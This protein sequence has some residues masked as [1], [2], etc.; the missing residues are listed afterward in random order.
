MDFSKQTMAWMGQMVSM[1]E[2]NFWMDFSAFYE[3]LASP[4]EAD[5]WLNEFTREILDVKHERVKRHSGTTKTL[6]RECVRCLRPHGSIGFPGSWRREESWSES[7][8]M[9]MFLELRARIKIVKIFG[10]PPKHHCLQQV[11]D[12]WREQESNQ[13]KED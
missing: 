8:S 2:P 11:S 13:A 12:G 7:F 4:D 10:E 6:G 5:E 9:C 1:K 3:V